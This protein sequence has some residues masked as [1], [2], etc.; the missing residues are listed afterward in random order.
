MLFIDLG[1]GSASFSVPSEPGRS[2]GVADPDDDQMAE[3][4]YISIKELL[5]SGAELD[6][7]WKPCI[8]AEAGERITRDSRTN[9]S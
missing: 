5:D 2:L 6:I 1:L 7:E 8:Y 9:Y 4:G 3:W